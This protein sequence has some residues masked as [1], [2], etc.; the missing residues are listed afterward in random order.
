MISQAADAESHVHHPGP[1]W[2]RK[3]YLHLFFS[4]VMAAAAQLFMKRGAD[5]A[6]GTHQIFG[7]GG[8]ASGWVWLGIVSHIASL[9]SWLYALR[10]APLNIAYY[11]AGLT[12]ALVPLG[13][14]FFLHEQIQLQRWAGVAIICLGVAITARQV[15]KVEEQL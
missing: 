3:P 1:G 7:F 2:W 11:V 15:G 5:D 8:L 14:W 10:Y 4:I 6:I 9:L 12:Q 13:S